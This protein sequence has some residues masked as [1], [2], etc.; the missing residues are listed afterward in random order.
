MNELYFLK[1]YFLL[2]P[3]L[4]LISYVCYVSVLDFS[5]S[6]PFFFLAILVAVVISLK[7]FQV[8]QEVQQCLIPD[9]PNDEYQRLFYL[10][11]LPVFFF[12][13]SF[14]LLSSSSSFAFVDE[15]KKKTSG[16]V[17]TLLVTSTP[18]DRSQRGRRERESL[19][20][21]LTE[22]TGFSGLPLCI[23]F[24]FFLLPLFRPTVFRRF[25]FHLPVSRRAHYNSRLC[26]RFEY[27]MI[28][29]STGRDYVR[30]IWG[31]CL[32]PTWT[33]T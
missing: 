3:S 29:A 7:L 16:S 21:F 12:F 1:F 32:F 24:E 26:R 18:L 5:L 22:Q 23:L 14:I 33:N 15:K 27:A 10:D 25:F 11:G 19:S 30:I 4:T 13:R 20:L 8:Y 9:L 31:W 28:S 2:L 17:V 6:A